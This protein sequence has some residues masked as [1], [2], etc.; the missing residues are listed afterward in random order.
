MQARKLYSLTSLVNPHVDTRAS[1]SFHTDG[2]DGLHETAKFSGEP[3]GEKTTGST[4]VFDK[5]GA[6]GKAFTTD[7]V[8][9]GTAQKVGGPFDKN[10]AVG[11]AFTT[12]GS[13]GGTVQ[14]R[15]GKGET[16][17]FQTK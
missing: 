14:E 3:A 8:L 7:G 4:S 15:L 2:A 17:S 9:G 12:S 6:I 10:G 5:D 13:I 11:S 16:S 1:A